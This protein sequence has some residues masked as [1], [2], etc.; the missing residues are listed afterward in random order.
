MDDQKKQF[1]IEKFE[2]ALANTPEEVRSFLWS[3]TYQNILNA[4]QKKFSL[5]DEQKSIINDIIFGSLTKTITESKVEE[6]VE[7]IVLDEEKKTELLSYVFYYFIEPSIQK[8]EEIFELEKK[9]ESDQETTSFAPSPAQA[10]ESIKERLSQSV[11]IAP[12]K[13]DYSL[14]KSSGESTQSQN[15]VKPSI[16]PYREI[17]DKD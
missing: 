7:K 13:R 3:D 6:S 12:V 16:D 5:S 15:I 14:E 11:K 8:T 2:N 10:L 9:E 17:P 4:L 1:D